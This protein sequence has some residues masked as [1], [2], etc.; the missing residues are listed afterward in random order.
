MKTNLTRKDPRGGAGRNQGRK[1]FDEVGKEKKKAYG[2]YLKPTDYK[3]LVDKHGSITRA[4]EKL[5]V[6]ILILDTIS[7]I[8]IL[9]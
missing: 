7:L 2:A 8:W 1:R 3:H 4:L 5:L 9:K 6:V